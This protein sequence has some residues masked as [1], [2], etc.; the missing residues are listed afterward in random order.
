MAD[1]FKTTVSRTLTTDN[2]QYSNLI[3]QAGKPPLDSELNLVGQIATDNLA[4]VVSTNAHSGILLDPR[5]SMRDFTFN[6]L[7]SNFLKVKGFKA[8]VNG[9]VVN[10]AESQINLPPPPA[11]DFRVDFVFLEV[12]KGVISAQGSG[13]DLTNKNTD[14]TV[15]ENGNIAGS[16][17][18]DEMVDSNVGFETTKRVQVQYRF[19]VV[20]GIDLK[21][22]IEGM[23]SPL[24]FAQG[25]LAG[26]SARTFSNQHSNGDAG[27]WLS[28]MTSDGLPLDP[29]NNTALSV[30]LSENIVYGIP[31]CSISR[32]NK[33][34][35]VAF[36][37]AG[38]A[39][40]N[41]GFKCAPSG[42]GGPGGG[43]R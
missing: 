16:G 1:D 38:V 34:A 14:T 43:C 18:A 29:P 7:W 39:N 35:Y 17:L 9:L 10:V 41:G 4:K 3:W 22:Q 40:Q 24:V 12:W 31:V 42:G 2:R 23:S 19:R 28:H 26:V 11:T 13:G 6:P 33:N 37:G 5:S 30:L 25:P 8:L 21:S 15:Y 27:L 36:A 20:S 32:R